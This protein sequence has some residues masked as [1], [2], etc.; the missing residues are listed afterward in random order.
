VDKW[1]PLQAINKCEQRIWTNSECSALICLVAHPL[2]GAA[3]SYTTTSSLRWRAGPAMDRCEAHLTTYPPRKRWSG[4]A[5]SQARH[6]QQN[7]G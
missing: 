1:S 5:R 4:S 3:S 2:W 6:C 7:G